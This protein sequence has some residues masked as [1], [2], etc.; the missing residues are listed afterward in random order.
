[1]YESNVTTNFNPFGG[2]DDLQG[3]NTT[4]GTALARV[5]G[6]IGNDLR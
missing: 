3:W 4:G 5:W 1:M 6:F 2:G